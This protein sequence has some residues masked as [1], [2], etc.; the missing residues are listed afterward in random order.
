MLEIT[1]RHAIFG[2]VIS[3]FNVLKEEG[4]IPDK[5]RCNKCSDDASLALYK[6][7]KKYRII[8]R[9]IKTACQS[10]QTLINTKIGIHNFLYVIYKLLLGSKYAD[11]KLDV[12]IS[13]STLVSIKSKLRTVISGYNKSKCTLLGGP[14]I[15][16]QCDETVICRRGIIKCPSHA[17]DNTKDT[18]WILGCIE[19]TEDRKFYIRRVENR[20]ANT[21]TEALE[22]NIGVGTI[23]HTDGYPS[24][25]QVAQNLSLMHRVVNHTEGFVANDGTHTNLIEGFWANLKE[26]MRAEHGVARQNIDEWIEFYSFRRRFV[27]GKDICEITSLFLEIVRLYIKCIS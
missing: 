26:R 13:V 25:P 8:Y 2:S 14:G 21:I 24:Y 3:C 10:K 12:K 4:L 18:V 7:K 11:I 17:D 19:D 9:C 23:F 27:D 15:V 20:Q 5:I 6:Q 1:S 22:G 16:V